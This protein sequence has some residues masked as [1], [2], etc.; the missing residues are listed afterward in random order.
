MAKTPNH[1]RLAAELYILQKQQLESIE[2][3]TFCGWTPDASA[4]YNK[5]ADRIELLLSRLA[6][7]DKTP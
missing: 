4:Q 7:P 3:A 5:R 6:V 2:N 1:K